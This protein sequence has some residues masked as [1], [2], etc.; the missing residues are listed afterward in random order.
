MVVYW[1]C[2]FPRS[3]RRF[4]VYDCIDRSDIIRET[5]SMS[6]ITIRNLEP[7]IKERLRFRAA[8]MEAEARRILREAL[9]GSRGLQ[10]AV[11]MSASTRASRRLAVSIWSFPTR[12][13]PRTAP[14]RL[15]F[16]LDTNILSA[17]MAPNPAPGVRYD[18]RRAASTTLP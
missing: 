17:M 18:V 1:A 15:M 9:R 5:V 4:D 12:T 10:A 14:L 7:A 11:F 2:S 13:F 3:N 16:V 6:S 8:L